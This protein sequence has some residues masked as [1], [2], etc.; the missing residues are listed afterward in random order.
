MTLAEAVV[1]VGSAL[2][3]HYEDNLGPRVI[4]T[5]RINVGNWTERHLTPDHWIRR[6]LATGPTIRQ[7]DT[8]GSIQ[9]IPIVGMRVR[10]Y[11][12]HWEDKLNLGNSLR[13]VHLV[14]DILGPILNLP[15]GLIDRKTLLENEWLTQWSLLPIPL[16]L[17]A[18]HYLYG[19]QA[20]TLRPCSIMDSPERVRQMMEKR[21]RPL[22]VGTHRPSEKVHNVARA[23]PYGIFSHDVAHTLLMSLFAMTD[24]NFPATL[25]KLDDII[26][27]LFTGETLG[28]VRSVSLDGPSP[29][30]SKIGPNLALKN[31]PISLTMQQ[32]HQLLGSPWIVDGILNRRRFAKEVRRLI[33]DDPSLPAHHRAELAVHLDRVFT[34]F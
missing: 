18:F 2:Q 16:F 4:P 6:Y 24:N 19:D 14:N 3:Y 5:E 22:F 32:I 31:S 12:T 8:S 11:E 28:K 15:P 17:G 7:A 34:F 21:Q 33:A 1:Q 10:S 20:Y 23:H 27:S 30:P 9:E 26:L 29:D 13:L 25:L